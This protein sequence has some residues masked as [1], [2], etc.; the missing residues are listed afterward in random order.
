MGYFTKIHLKNYR[1]FINYQAEFSSTCNV[2]YGKNGSGKTNILEGISLFGQGKGIRKDNILNLIK[3]NQKQFSNLGIFEENNNINE[4]KVFSEKIN[5]QFKK[6]ISLNNDSAKES[7]KHLYSLYSFVYFLPEMERL[8]LLSPS[9]RR[10]FIDNFIF[11]KNNKYH[12]TINKYK[13]LIYERSKLLNYQSYDEVWLKKIEEQ[14]SIIGIE[15]YQARNMQLEKLEEQLL[16]LNQKKK[17]PFDLS[18]KLIDNFYSNKLDNETYLNSLQSSRD[19][20]KIIGGAKE[21]PHKSD[22]SFFVKNNYPASQLST[23]QQKTIILLLILA[24]C[25]YLVNEC[26]LSPILLMDEIC[27][28]LDENNRE[29]LMQLTQDF[30]I[31]IF[32]TGTD[33]NLFSF[34]STNTTFCNINN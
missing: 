6:K 5:D 21:G 23:G 9:Y 8:F 14:I 7:I 12:L 3:I 17:L 28:H 18:I 26:N 34:L 4:I 2:F 19:V 29:I 11:S 22:F 30:E 32:M 25:H 31:Q 33:K 10:N 16:S 13:K 27:S 1:N 24:Q 15:I 20:D